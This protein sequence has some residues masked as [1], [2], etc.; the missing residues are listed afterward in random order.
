[1]GLFISFEGGEGCGK[2]TQARHLAAALEQRG[3]DVVLTYEPGGTP[4][5]EEL[6]RCLKRSR[7][8]GLTAEAELLLFGAARSQLTKTVILPSL[9][10]GSVVVCDRYSDSTTAY[11][12]YGRMLPMPTVASVNRLADGGL[13]PNLVIL[14]DMDPTKALERKRRW[15]DRFE[16]ESSEFHERVRGG[17]LELAAAEPD[18]WLVVDAACA[19]VATSQRI[20]SRVAQVLEECPGLVRRSS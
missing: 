6:R 10:R 9:M 7:E 12:G 13:R 8:G 18:R 19:P 5:G 4:L 3:Y 20:W 16:G 11:Q 1:M 14:L 17:Y 2:S 15:R